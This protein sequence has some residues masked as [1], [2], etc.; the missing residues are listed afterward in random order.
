MLTDTHCHIF[1]K[2]YQN[3]EEIL[4]SLNENNIKRVILN[5]YNTETNNEVIKLIKKYD[6]VY[7]ALGIHPNHLSPNYEKELLFIKEN[8]NNPKIIAIGEIGLDFYWNKEEKEQQLNCFA[9]LLDIAAEYNK[10]V[11]IHS[12]EATADTIKMLSGYNLKGVIHCFSGSYEVAKEYI[13]MG[14]KLGIN[15]IVTFKNSKLPDTLA[16]L[17]PKNIL[18]ETDC[19]YITPEPYRKFKNEP[20]YLDSIA[21]KIAEIYDLDDQKLAETLEANFFEIFDI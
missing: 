9:K 20:K 16:K 3:V 14:Y 10:P 19:P 12:R 7:G 17:D 18:L 1:S 2:E 13:K 15:G 4:S 5:G 6:N 8:I 21:K 11:I